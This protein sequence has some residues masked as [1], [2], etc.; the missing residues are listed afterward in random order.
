MSTEET[1][2]IPQANS[3]RAELWTTA[4]LII[5]T[6][7]GIFLYA[8]DSTLIPASYAIIGSEFNQLEHVA[9]I[10]TAYMLVLAGVQPLYGKLSDILGRKTCLLFAYGVYGLGCLLCGASQSLSQLVAARALA[11]VGGA[12]L[13][14]LV[15]ILVADLVPLRAVGTWTGFLNIIFVMGQ[16]AGSPIGGILADGPGW[17]WAFLMQVPLLLLAV[18]TVI[19]MV[20]EVVQGSAQTTREKLRRVDFLGAAC[21]VCTVLLLLVGLDRA[22]NRAWLE[23]ITIGLLLCAVLTAMLFWIVE[24]KFAQEPFAPPQMLWHNRL[25][26]PYLCDFFSI[27]SDSCLI[28]FLPLY[29]QAVEHKTA[30]V[31]GISLVP[32]AICA[33]A[34]TIAGGMSV[35]KLGKFW[36]PVFVGYLIQAIGSL[37]V[38]LALS[39]PG[40]D[41]RII[42]GAYA[43]SSFGCGFG[44]TTTVVAIVA[45]AGKD[46][47][48]VALAVS[49]L[50]RSFGGV[51]GILLGGTIIQNALRSIL[52]V[53]LRDRADIDEIVSGVRASLSYI[54]SLPLETQII[55][56]ASYHDAVFYAFLFSALLGAAAVLSASWVVSKPLSNDTEPE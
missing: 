1:P 29:F 10:A 13:I 52:H 51:I 30:A 24:T 53:K 43:I 47:K 5:P 9:W 31:A 8:F 25:W 35:Q 16:T 55:V 32:A 41:Y 45:S 18:V 49:F 22:G 17:R 15:S 39:L 54:N 2:L 14:T 12:G 20:P 42:A 7:V 38:L 33:T 36:G 4:K 56:R 48:A 3:K 26:A 50:F 19:I 44:I 27:A 40:A 21:L 6:G 37:L 23:P 28:F 46:L 11:G 34:G